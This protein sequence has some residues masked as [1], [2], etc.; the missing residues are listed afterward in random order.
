RLIAKIETRAAIDNFDDILAEADGIM[1]ARGDLG[2]DVPFEDVPLIQ[3]DLLKRAANADKFTIVATQM[4]ESMTAAPRP[5]RAEVS[6]VANAVL[7]GADAVM[8]SA[9]TAIGAFPVEAL[10]A[11][12]RICSKTEQDAPDH[13]L[14]H[15]G[16]ADFES[17]ASVIV[18]AASGIAHFASAA[19]RGPDAIWC[20]TRTGRT[21]EML[22][23]SRPH[24]PVV[25]FTLS[26]IVA[27]RLA[28]RR[29]VIPLVL[30]TGNRQSA[31]ASLIERMSAAWR[32]QRGAAHHERV[33]LVTTSRQANG[34]NRLEVHQVAA[35]PAPT[36][37]PARPT[38]RRQPAQQRRSPAQAP[39]PEPNPETATEDA[40]AAAP[41]SAAES[42][43]EPVAEP[44]A[45]VAPEPVA[46][47]AV[48]DS[49]PTV[50]SERETESEPTDASEP[51]TEAEV[52]AS[53]DDAVV[54]TEEP[55]PA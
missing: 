20:F 13:M 34:I 31:P 18:S 44:E 46:D 24:V 15:G 38:E 32:A 7:D 29:G 49:E 12:E 45:T 51:E 25:A 48:A 27:R 26:P 52:P 54:E 1:V 39:A 11:M 4:L 30:P 37:T 2:V 43:P 16:P 35:A 40:P 53:S 28:V 33:L 23:V 8:L 47:S 9:E 41:E 22:A 50:A 55:A 36:P 10:Q 6:D 17:D 5:T 42:A 14:A 3:K 19:G 21:A